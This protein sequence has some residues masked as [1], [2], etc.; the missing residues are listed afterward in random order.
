[1]AAERTATSGDAPTGEPERGHGPSAPDP[2]TP[3]PSAP[4]PSPPETPTSGPA[5]RGWIDF[6]LGYQPAFNGLRGVAF[7]LIILYHAEVYRPDAHGWTLIPTAS[8]S[9]LGLEMFFVQSGFLIVTLL[10]EEWYRT[11]FI[12]F[13]YFYARRALR[14]L[15]ALLVLF[16]AVLIWTSIV[17]PPGV[18][19]GVYSDV[20]AA[21][22]YVKNWHQIVGTRLP[23]YLDALWSLSVEEQFY[24]VAPVA[25]LW[26]LRKGWTPRRIATALFVL[27]GVSATWMAIL[28]LGTSPIE[29]LYV[30][31]DTRA[32]AFLVGAA[33]A[34]L[35]SG[36]VLFRGEASRRALRI[37]AWVATGVIV[38][39]VKYFSQTVRGFYIGGYLLASICFAL[40]F[41]YIVQEPHSR[42]AR[43]LSW[44]P[45]AWTGRVSYGL[46]IW[47][48]PVIFVLAPRTRDWPLPAALALFTV[49]T[50]AIGALSWYLVE[51]PAL[52]Y[53]RRFRRAGPARDTTED[54]AGSA[55]AA[56]TA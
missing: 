13:R 20:L 3:G 52:R 43:I 30:G 26:V 37:S 36:G 12:R 31:T 32:Q 17:D 27:A 6:R 40:M 24:L 53:A 51:T 50:F 4:G 23:S 35:A 11:G 5:G 8:G 38:V 46:Y 54:A 2:P 49:T 47:H 9:F 25:V 16:V 41:A 39:L 56:E 28:A 55:V 21:A 15:P 44:R 34:V 22:F 33:F 18:R 42:Y 14:L 48:Y 45:L 19:R 7:A 10:I 1:M 29:R